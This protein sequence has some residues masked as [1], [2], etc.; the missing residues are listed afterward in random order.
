MPVNNS[1]AR[2]NMSKLVQALMSERRM[3]RNVG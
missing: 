1:I 2:K 3:A